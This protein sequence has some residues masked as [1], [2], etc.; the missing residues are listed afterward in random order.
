MEDKYII[1]KKDYLA[2]IS[3]SHNLREETENPICQVAFDGEGGHSLI[4]VL[5]YEKP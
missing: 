2:S 5:N 4:N 3:K 1:E